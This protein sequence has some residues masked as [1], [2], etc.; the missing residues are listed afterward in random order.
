[1]KKASIP[2]IMGI[3]LVEREAISWLWVHPIKNKEI[4]MLEGIPPNK[5]PIFVLNF[6]AIIVAKVTQILPTEKAKISLIV[7]MSIIIF[8]NNIS[9]L[10]FNS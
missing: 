7:K 5:P 6:S 10:T 8:L 4:T 3:M 2:R 1:M 9:S